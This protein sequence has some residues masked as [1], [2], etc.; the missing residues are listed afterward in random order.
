MDLKAHIRSIPDYPEPGIVFRDITPLLLDPDALQC[1]VDS[2]VSEV[3]R[4][5]SR[6]DVVVGIEARGF[7]FGPPVALALG[8]G[9]VPVRKPGKLPFD[10]VELTYDLEYGTDTIAVHTDAIAAG[11]RVLIVDDLLA[12]GGTAEACCRLVEQLGGHVVACAFVVEL[13]FLQAR[14]KF[15]VPVIS[16]IDYEEE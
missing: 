14:E 11:Q 15:T 4:L 10:T 6:I 16:L 5:G 2:V 3:R 12:T 7:L 9:F 1:T 13:S 8:V